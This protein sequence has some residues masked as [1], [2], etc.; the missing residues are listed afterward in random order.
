MKIMPSIQYH[1]CFD[2][3]A[4][5]LRI[6]IISSLN[7]RPMSVEELSEKVG[8]ERSRVSHSLKTLRVCNYVDVEK[9]GKQRIYALRKGILAEHADPVSGNDIF[10]FVENHFEYHCM[11]ECRK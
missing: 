9:Q 4:N 5:E 6:K 3:L 11:G 7:E 10:R 8:A 2:T 1:K